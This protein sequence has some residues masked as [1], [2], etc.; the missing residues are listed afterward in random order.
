MSTEPIK[1]IKNDLSEA[2]DMLTPLPAKALKYIKVAHGR[3]PIRI[4]ESFSLRQ[5]Y[6]DVESLKR[7]IIANGVRDPIVC[8]VSG[9][10]QG[11][12]AASY[13]VEKGERRWFAVTKAMAE[14]INITHV[15]V[16]I[17]DNADPAS[18]IIDQ[19]LRNQAKPL[20]V[21]EIA[22][23]IERLRSSERLTDE[24]IR[25]LLGFT[26]EMYQAHVDVLSAPDDVSK[27]VGE[28]I[29]SS[30]QVLRLVMAGVKGH[31]LS[32]AVECIASTLRRCTGEEDA[33]SQD[34]PEQISKKSLSD[35]LDRLIRRTHFATRSKHSESKL[36]GFRVAVDL[37]NDVL[38]EEEAAS[39]LVGV[40]P[41]KGRK[42]ISTVIKAAA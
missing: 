40:F 14:G 10:G 5:E 21:F 20:T 8:H 12:G 28:G 26:P 37:V 27:A 41:R 30:E 29:V 31:Q 35:M 42:R 34:S 1:P 7:S 16:I 25:E 23:G 17:V 33:A 32:A 22:H 2:K 13:I 15:P 4:Q 9:G 11:E 24:E 3:S 19:L 36:V 6:G 38:D 18:R 39:A